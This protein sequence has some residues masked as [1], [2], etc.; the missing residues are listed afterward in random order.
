MLGLADIV[1]GASNLRISTGMVEHGRA[2]FVSHI[3]PVKTKG[4]V[5]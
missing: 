2:H 5:L 3:L 1:Q 4:V